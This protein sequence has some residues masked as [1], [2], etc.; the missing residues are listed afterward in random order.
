MEVMNLGEGLVKVVL[1][2]RLDTQGVERLEARFIAA[3]VPPAN[4]AIIDL[5]AVEF[6]ASMGIRMLI[7]VARSLNQR[8]ARLV[9]FGASSQV[10]DVFEA[11]SLQKIIPVCASETD[12][13][14]SVSTP[15]A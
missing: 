13:L 6:V 14:A 5:S 7:S 1:T 10:K 2:G 15:Q 11:V 4:N 3:T 9:L 8:Q 12:A